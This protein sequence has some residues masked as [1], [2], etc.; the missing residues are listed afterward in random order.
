MKIFSFL[1]RAEQ[2]QWQPILQIHKCFCSAAAPCSPPDRGEK[3]DTRWVAGQLV[4]RDTT[5]VGSLTP[6]SGEFKT[7]GREGGG[8]KLHKVVILSLM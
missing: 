3:N 6:V 7:E 5:Q 8:A 2:Q 4:S 1:L